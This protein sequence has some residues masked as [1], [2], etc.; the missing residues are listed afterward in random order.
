MSRTVI[1]LYSDAETAKKAVAALIDAGG[2]EEDIEIV[3]AG[4]R[5]ES[6]VTKL[7]E[8]GF[9][10][11]A[12][13][14]F[15]EAGQKGK[16]LVL[17]EIADD[18]VD[19]ANEILRENGG[20]QLQRLST[21]S[22]RPRTRTE[23]ETVPIVEEHIEIGKRRE[24]SGGVRVTSHVTATPVRETVTLREE[25]VD[26]KRRRVNRPLERNEAAGAF[27]DRTIEAENSAEKAE[28]HKEARV[29]GEV[30]ITR[31]VTE[32][33]ETVGG[34]ERKTEVAVEKI[35]DRDDR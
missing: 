33:R 13:Q 21:T 31:N 26:V 29:T 3:K 10:E 15:A 18:S 35:R 23:T 9:N 11:K 1:G 8:H 25:E 32:R 12:A 34:T 2:H 19:A 6:V 14:Q 27:E 5:S 24:T 4:S 20:E 30:E 7:T 28:V 16:T 22:E 17:A